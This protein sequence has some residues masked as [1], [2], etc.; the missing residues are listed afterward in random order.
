MRDVMFGTTGQ[1]IMT[2]KYT[3]AQATQSCAKVL[4]VLEQNKIS[5]AFVLDDGKPVGLI[6]M[7]SL[8]QAGV[9]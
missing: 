9:A 2:T 7:L 8:I 4:G 3:Y 6:R 5:A 1:T